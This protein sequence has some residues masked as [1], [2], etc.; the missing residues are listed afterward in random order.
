M[1]NKSAVCIFCCAASKLKPDVNPHEE[2]LAIR[3][4]DTGHRSI[5]HDFAD[6]LS[7]A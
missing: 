3:N 2:R 4:D 7:T 6:A 5:K 1:K